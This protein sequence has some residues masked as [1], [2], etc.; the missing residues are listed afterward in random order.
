MDLAVSPPEL[1]VYTPELLW[2]RALEQLDGVYEKLSKIDGLIRDGYALDNM[3]KSP[4]C[5]QWSAA[6]TRLVRAEVGL[7]DRSATVEVREWV[8]PIP[9]R[10]SQEI[11]LLHRFVSISLTGL[12]PR[13]IDGT[14]QQFLQEDRRSSDLPKILSG[15]CEQVTEAA[16]A[17]GIRQPNI[18]IWRDAGKCRFQP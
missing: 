13:V 6:A 1:V 5:G 16:H 12:E 9:I 7:F 11:P 3:F 10:S 4:V 14:W 8:P 15:N 18:R 17:A 2:D